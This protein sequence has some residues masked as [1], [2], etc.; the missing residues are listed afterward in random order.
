MNRPNPPLLKRG[1]QCW[2]LSN[3]GNLWGTFR[4]RKDAIDD[5][6]FALGVPW[7]EAKAS[8]EVR[9]VTVVEG[10]GESS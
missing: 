3:F 8:M 1:T 10:W 5:A 9:K 4:T 7:S 6:E 2:A